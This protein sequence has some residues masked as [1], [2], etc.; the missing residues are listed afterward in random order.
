MFSHS[1]TRCSSLFSLS[2]LISF[3]V[4]KTDA[5][6]TQKR[7]NERT[8][9]QICTA[10]MKHLP[11]L[12]FSN[13]LISFC[14]EFFYSNE[15]KTTTTNFIWRVSI[16]LSRTVHFIWLLLLSVQIISNST[17]IIH[18]DLLILAKGHLDSLS[19]CM[20]VCVMCSTA[21]SL[22][23]SPSPRHSIPPSWD[24]LQSVN[25]WV[26]DIPFVYLQKTS[27]KNFIFHHHHC[28]IALYAINTSQI[29][30]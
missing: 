25:R 11:T 22:S 14:F 26:N 24:I 12:L 28:R 19:L 9:N 18:V 20:C 30:K 17:K 6:S 23:L 2:L 27:E 21:Y 4:R 13:N 5:K 16:F 3:F 8:I 7:N 29:Y 1:N 15:E 10:H